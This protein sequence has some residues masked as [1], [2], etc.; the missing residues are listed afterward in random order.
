MLSSCCW[1]FAAH[2]DSV[3]E[4]ARTEQTLG[5]GDSLGSLMF[6]RALHRR[7]LLGLEPPDEEPLL[8]DPQAWLLGHAPSEAL[9]PEDGN[10]R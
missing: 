5:A 8:L 2:A 3:P 7:R 1:P 4:Y 6:G 9:G 10:G